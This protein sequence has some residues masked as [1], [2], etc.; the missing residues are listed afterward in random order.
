MPS[1]ERELQ[2]NCPRISLHHSLLNYSI[3]MGKKIPY[4]AC[5]HRQITD[6]FLQI[7]FLHV[8]LKNTVLLLYC[9]FRINLNWY[10]CIL[11]II[12]N[13]MILKCDIFFNI[14]SYFFLERLLFIWVILWDMIN[15]NYLYRVSV[16]RY[17]EVF[18]SVRIFQISCIY[19][20]GTVNNQTIK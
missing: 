9:C 4:N 10:R 1:V 6:L 18:K 2:T 14:L 8:G 20:F 16:R 15:N 7:P 17:K 11:H 19:W 12:C 5:I 13:K 3:F